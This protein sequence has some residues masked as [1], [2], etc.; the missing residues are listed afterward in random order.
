MPSLGPMELVLILFIVLVVFGAGRLAGLGSA[1]GTSLREFRKATAEP[2][3]EEKPEPDKPAEAK[4]AEPKPV[5]AK[6]AVVEERK[7]IRPPTVS[8][9]EEKAATVEPAESEHKVS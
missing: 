2:D 4:P 1:L 6:T 3:E 7:E 8:I 9:A 5:E